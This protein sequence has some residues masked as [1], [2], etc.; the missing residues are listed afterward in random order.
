M[1][2]VLLVAAGGAIGSVLRW[3]V[4]VW[5]ARPG[6]A[7]F[8]WSTLAVNL[9]GSAA[10]GFVLALATERAG[11]PASLRLFVA[12]GVLGGFTT[13]SAFSWETLSLARDGH[14]LSATAYVL[15]SVLGGLAAAA[16]GSAIAAKF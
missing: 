11:F 13:F 7:A 15:A 12:T 4:S 2:Q 1:K 9:L 14:A 6:P 3:A 8:P 16:G 5:L 10:I